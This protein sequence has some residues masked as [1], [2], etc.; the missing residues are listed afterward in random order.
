[1]A[2]YVLTSDLKGTR[3]DSAPPLCMVIVIAKYGIGAIKKETNI[4]ELSVTRSDLHYQ[5]D[6]ASI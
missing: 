4:K 3:A 1:M 5:I 6:K 2:P